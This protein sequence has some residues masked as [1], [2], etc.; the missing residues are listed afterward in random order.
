MVL[1]VE[2]AK[3]PCGHHAF[4]KIGFRVPSSRPGLLTR[5][6]ADPDSD[7]VAFVDERRKAAQ[8]AGEV[9]RARQRIDVEAAHPVAREG[10]YRMVCRARVA[11]RSLTATARP[12]QG[13]RN[14]KPAVSLV[15]SVRRA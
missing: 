8:A 12:T 7:C 9:D 11:R 5:G 15:Q 14:G 10:W 3:T 2:D 1:I 6:L 13:R 4:H